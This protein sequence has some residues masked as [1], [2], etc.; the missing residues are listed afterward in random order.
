MRGQPFLKMSGAALYAQINGGRDAGSNIIDCCDTIETTGTCLESE[1][2][3]PKIFEWQIPPGVLKFK[4]D[5]Q[6]KVTI[7]TFADACTALN[8]NMLPQFPLNATQA[9]VQNRGFDPNGVANLSNSR[10]SN[11]SVHGAG[12]VILNGT[13]FIILPNS[14]DLTWGPWTRQ[15]PPWYDAFIAR[16]NITP[17]DALPLAGCCLI[18]EAHIDNCDRTDDAYAHGVSL[19]GPSDTSAPEVIV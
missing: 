9:W 13:P 3:F 19:T 15:N 11:H 1:M 4:E 16:N 18:G 10:S 7:T 2:D 8:M 6:V 17:M 5:P 12:L 14:W